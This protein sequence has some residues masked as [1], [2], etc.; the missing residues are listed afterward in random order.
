MTFVHVPADP[1]CREYL[2]GPEDQRHPGDTSTHLV[3]VLQLWNQC[4][5]VSLYVTIKLTF[6]PSFPCS[7]LSPLCPVWPYQSKNTWK[8]MQSRSLGWVELCIFLDTHEAVYK[9]KQSMIENLFTLNPGIPG[10][11]E[12][13]GGQI[14][15][16]CRSKGQIMSTVSLT[17]CRC[18]RMH[19]WILT[20]RSPLRS[21][22]VPGRP[23]TKRNHTQ[24]E[25]NCCRLHTIVTMSLILKYILHL[26]GVHQGQEVQEV[27]EGPQ[28]PDKH[29][30]HHQY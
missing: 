6:S 23:W 16:H 13:P 25:I 29:T 22:R 20:R 30:E 5:A 11:P 3:S 7:P 8:W 4:F 14:A 12:G 21:W 27:L 26:L 17:L 2:V 24:E 18:Q 28:D 15:G 10:G 1:Q 9:S 19:G